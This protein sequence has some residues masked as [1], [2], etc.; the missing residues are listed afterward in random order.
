MKNPEEQKPNAQQ[1]F[2]P[3]INASVAPD[4]KTELSASSSAAQE[5]TEDNLKN[6]NKKALRRL[7]RKYKIKHYYRKSPASL[8]RAI[9]RAMARK[10][11]IQTA[12]SALEITESKKENKALS[13]QELAEKR[14]RE[15]LKAYEEHRLRYLFNPSRFVYKGTHEDY[16]LDDE[17][18]LEL[19]DFYQE[20]ELVAMP[21]DPMRFYMYWD[22]A[23]ETLYDVRSW[24]A[25]ETPFILR[26][27]DVTGLVFDGKNAHNSWE[28][29]CHP[30][31][32]EWYLDTP[33]S[34]RN[35][36]VEMGVLL[37][38]GFHSIL[39]SNTI[40]I[41][42]E[43]VSS[44]KRDVFAHF[45]PV[46]VKETDPEPVIAEAVIAE[47]VVPEAE[48]ALPPRS[49]SSAHAFFQAYT[50]DPVIY[51]PA[52]PPQ[53][54]MDVSA[55]LNFEPLRAVMPHFDTQPGAPGDD[56]QRQGWD[57]ALPPLRQRQSVA[58]QQP[59]T[60]WEPVWESEPASGS[61]FAGQTTSNEEMGEYLSSAGQEQVQN[62][63][64]VP[65]EIR[66]LSDLPM[67]MSP[68]FYEQWITDPYDRA[69]V[70]SY[71]IWPWELTEYLPLGSSDWTLRKFL[72]ASLFS[73][74][75]PGGSERMRWWQRPVGASERS[76]WFRPEGA[77]E[78]SWSGTQQAEREQKV[79]PWYLWPRP[80]NQSGRGLFA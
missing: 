40:Y 26:V 11:D 28:V 74:Y 34:G 14:R 57:A 24:L 10:G 18:E 71:S 37:A 4:A 45:V 12:V 29:P 70:I 66:W 42:A 63:L 61:E 64:G 73:W 8:R 23:E 52:P 25:E 47:A 13:P 16:I 76:S 22:F 30:L 59:Q 53:R 75:R 6:L 43:S 58:P 39:R 78:R 7:A 36:L 44:V 46:Q 1:R 2:S 21:I 17:K 20:D 68:V 27:H 54:I 80:V 9:R 77:S 33:V 49:E 50:P 56:A 41:P 3:E 67:G 38:E 51:D 19:P 72:G 65:H 69:V 62:W 55:P 48:L 60:V 35:I 5:Q 15:A 32:R 31:V 79:H